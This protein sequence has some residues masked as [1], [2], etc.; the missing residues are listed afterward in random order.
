MRPLTQRKKAMF[1][2]EESCVIRRIYQ[3]EYNLLKGKL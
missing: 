2:A 3:D 1:K